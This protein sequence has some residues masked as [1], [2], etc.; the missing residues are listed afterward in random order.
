MHYISKREE[1]RRQYENLN[2]IARKIITDSEMNL[3]GLTLKAID[4]FAIDEAMRWRQNYL[5]H[6]LYKRPA[7]DW[8]KQWRKV[9]GRPRAVH[10]AIWDE[11]K[12]F[13]LAL[14]RISKG[15]VNV[16]C[17][18]F[19]A[20][21]LKRRTAL[22]AGEIVFPYLHIIGGLAR[23]REIILDSP[24]ASLYQFYRDHGFSEPEKPKSERNRIIMKQPINA[25]VTQ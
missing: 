10:L 13:A 18:F 20:D 12:L 15:R 8:H 16:T 2:S 7:W 3:D 6:D 21:P 22:K 14:G 25:F 4:V 11:D 19:E 5:Q 24:V 17:Y 9:G 1:I 23:C